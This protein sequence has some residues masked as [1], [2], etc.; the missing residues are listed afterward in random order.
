MEV[1]LRHLPYSSE[2]PPRLAVASRFSKPVREWL[3][4]YRKL[5]VLCQRWRTACAARR[6]QRQCD[7]QARTITAELEDGWPM[8]SRWSSEESTPQ[9]ISRID[10]HHAHVEGLDPGSVQRRV[11]DSF[12]PTTIWMLTYVGKQSGH[13][14][15]HNGPLTVVPRTWARSLPRP[16]LLL[17]MLMIGLLD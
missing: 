2:F 17:Y 8:W 16:A 11:A 7:H 15:R 13:S 6:L 14:L 5:Q 3:R 10:Q 1:M 9:L 4:R 12:L